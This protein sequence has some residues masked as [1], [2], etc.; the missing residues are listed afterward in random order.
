MKNTKVELND[1]ELENVNGGMMF[2]VF[3]QKMPEKR[4]DE[5]YV[6]TADGEKVIPI[7]IVGGPTSSET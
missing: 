4:P 5:K 6:M 3:A 2:I 1:T 7:N